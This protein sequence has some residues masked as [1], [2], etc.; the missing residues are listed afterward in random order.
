[1]DQKYLDLL[2]RAERSFGPAGVTTVVARTK[3]IIGVAT[4]PES[5]TAAQS[6]LDKLRSGKVPDP[7]ELAALELMIRIMRPAPLSRHGALDDLPVYNHHE[8]GLV[9]AW[10]AFRVR[11]KPLLYSVG[12][13]DKPGA[14]ANGTGVGT[15]FLIRKDL[16][17][18]N[19]HVLDVLSCGSMVLQAG[20]VTVNFGQEY[21]TPDVSPPM[22]V[23]AA[24][25]VHPTLDLA[26]LRVAPLTDRPTLSMAAMG[27]AKDDR[28]VAVGY[29]S[30]DPVRN[31]LFVAKV[32]GADFGVKR[33]APGVVLSAR[34]P[35]LFHDCSTLGGNS[36]SPVLSMATAEVVGVH[37]SGFFMYRNQAVVVQELAAFLQQP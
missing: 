17:V 19:R 32:F 7:G 11:F 25:F 22:P 20:A 33:A 4:L 23:L 26:L 9:D 16:L 31:P 1:M 2:A 8:P 29:P 35:S 21:G 3:A 30:D 12:R 6:A 18:T 24:A 27:A 13:L 14:G 28:V 15:C 36:G 34:A 10:N 37:C 5:E